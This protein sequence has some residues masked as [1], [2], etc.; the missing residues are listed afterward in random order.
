MEKKKPVPAEMSPDKV[1]TI[2][3]KLQARLAEKLAEKDSAVDARKLPD[4][5]P[6]AIVDREAAQLLMPDPRMV[7]LD[8]TLEENQH[9]FEAWVRYCRKSHRR[10]PGDQAMMAV[11]QILSSEGLI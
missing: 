3:T 6:I 5:L 11:E 4:P 8:F 7:V 9:L 1:K 2:K 10:A